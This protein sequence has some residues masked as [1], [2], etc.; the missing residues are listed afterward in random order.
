MRCFG[1]VGGNMCGDNTVESGAKRRTPKH[2]AQE[3]IEDPGPDRFETVSIGR[4]F[5]WHYVHPGF[6]PELLSRSKDVELQVGV[7]QDTVSVDAVGVD[8]RELLAAGCVGEATMRK[9]RLVLR[10]SEESLIAAGR[11]DII[12]KWGQ[13][14]EIWSHMD[15]TV[16]RIIRTGRDE[17]ETAIANEV[18]RLINSADA[19][20]Y[21]ALVNVFATR[22]CHDNRPLLQ[23]CLQWVEARARQSVEDRRRGARHWVD[24]GVGL[25]DLDAW[26]ALAF[27]WNH[28][29]D[30]PGMACRF[31]DEIYGLDCV[32]RAAELLKLLFDDEDEARRRLTEQAS[33]EQRYISERLSIAA[34]WQWLFND[35]DKSRD[36]LAKIEIN[37]VAD[38]VR[39]AEAWYLLHGYRDEAV[40]L[41][42]PDSSEILE[43]YEYTDLSGG[44]LDIFNDEEKARSFLLQAERLSQ[45]RG[46]W[47]DCA[48]TWIGCMHN[49]D[50]AFRCMR[51]AEELSRTTDDYVSCAFEWHSLKDKEQAEQSLQRAEG[52]CRN[53]DDWEQ[54]ARTRKHMLKS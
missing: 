19:R 13:L 4:L 29:L 40:R 15:D 35:A 46:D 38:R 49:P 18:Q 48:R 31:V 45:E 6:I 21:T 32:Y 2:F 16:M 52:G 53:G 43:A 8:A 17:G 20:G 23:E 3:H 47:Q 42:E 30:D 11:G 50:E 7:L 26:S 25:C 10:A 39:C 34:A 12:E 28:A 27:C 1:L 36:Y 44:W 5:P 37:R 51:K 9:G 41:L 14:V 54:V 24:P 33:K 22:Y